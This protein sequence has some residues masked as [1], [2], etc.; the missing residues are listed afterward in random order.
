MNRKTER[1]FL[2]AISIV[3]CLFFYRLYNVIQA[4]FNDV[5]SR[6]QAGTMVNLNAKNPAAQ[7]KSL[8]EKGYY[9]ED[10]RDI[11]LIEATVSKA[12]KNN[13][14]LDNVGELNKR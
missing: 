11:D 2:L 13:K 10:P 14:V 3:L 1:I 6:I 12:L 5:D 4:K 9:F 8:L 7:L